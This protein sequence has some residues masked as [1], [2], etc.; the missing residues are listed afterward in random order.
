M[1]RGAAGSSAVNHASCI[2]LRCR[3]VDAWNI[4]R[5][6]AP[7]SC[8]AIF[9]GTKNLFTYHRTQVFQL[10]VRHDFRFLNEVVLG[11]GS[12]F[13]HLHSCIDWS[14]PLASSY[15]P[16]LA[17][18]ELFEQHKFG[19]MDLPLIVGQSGCWWHRSVAWW[20]LQT[21]SQS[22]RVMAMVINEI[23]YGFTTMLLA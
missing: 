19:R 20:R 16:K 10:Y 11:H 9:C 15:N 6:V 8:V 2:R 12:T 22:S 23:G 17:T 21:A 14:T 3:S 13:H 5:K 18:T 7:D 4:H 1:S